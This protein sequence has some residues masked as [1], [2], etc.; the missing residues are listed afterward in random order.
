MAAGD[1]I[2]KMDHHLAEKCRRLVY[3]T[4]QQ[5]GIPPVWITAHIRAV[6]ADRAR[7]EVWWVMVH[8]YRMSRQLVAKIFGRDRRR[9]RESVIGRDRKRIRA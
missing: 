3:K 4:A 7:R 9:I 8:Q 5:Y 6:T 2:T 1:K